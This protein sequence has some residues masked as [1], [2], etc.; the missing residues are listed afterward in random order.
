MTTISRPSGMTRREQV[1]DQLK[2]RV[3]QSSLLNQNF[4][5]F[6]ELFTY[7]SYPLR[8]RSTPKGKFVI[9]GTGR[10]GSTLLVNLLNSNS[11]IFC[12]NEI[13]HRKVMFP[14]LYLKFR[15]ILGNKS[16]YGFKCLTYHL[17]L[18]LNLETEEE[19]RAYLEKLVDRG[20]KIIYLRRH[21]I[22][23]QGLSNLYA[24]YKN[25][26]HSNAQAGVKNK[27]KKMPVEISELKRWMEA[28]DDQ[29]QVEAR[30]LEN[31]PHLKLSYEDD[32]SDAGAHPETFGKLSS[33]LGIDF[34]IP[35]TK[36][37]K[38]TPKSLDSFIENSD[39][40]IEFLHEHGY[41]SYLN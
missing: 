39:E 21:N 5:Y 8:K 12:D 32:L 4:G 3:K 6:F 10:S 20:F 40:V 36:L 31:L 41:E 11:N 7:L 27:G 29:A 28:L 23:R 1:L 22:F 2:Y 37:R 13:Y 16:V 33:F 35:E 17:G 15:S 30:L 18:S 26:F 38:V 19:K 24:R 9:F 14:L 34:E 25:Q